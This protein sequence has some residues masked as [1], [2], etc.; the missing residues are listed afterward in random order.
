L[1]AKIREVAVGLGAILR[2]NAPVI[3]FVA[4]TAVLL[5]ALY[6][7]SHIRWV[8][9]NFIEPYTHFVAACSRFCLRLIGVDAGG[10]GETIVSPQFSVSIKNVCNGLEVTAIF[11]AVT[12]GFPATWKHRLYGL[13]G[14][15]PVIFL[16]NIIRIVA[17]F[18]IGFKVPEVF[19]A[20]HFYYAQAFVIIVTVGIWLAW[21][22]TY[23]AYGSKSR[24]S[25][26]R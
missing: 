22:T 9:R 12:I 5:V 14:G 2:R 18:L 16:V 10:R 11:L 24:H 19:E 4:V 3:R 23:S 20:V 15:Y 7:L 6:A 25:V 13:L 17:L 26:S 21:V 8:E 1:S